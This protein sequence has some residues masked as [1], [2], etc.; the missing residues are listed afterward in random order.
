MAILKIVSQL[1]TIFFFP[2]IP[3]KRCCRL[4]FFSRLVPRKTR[5]DFLGFLL[6]LFSY[7]MNA[8][9]LDE[10]FKF[11]LFSKNVALLDMRWSYHTKR[12]TECGYP[13]PF[14]KIFDLFA[15]IQ[16]RR[17]NEILRCNNIS[18]SNG[19]VGVGIPI[20]FQNSRKSIRLLGKQTQ[21]ALIYPKFAK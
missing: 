4:W 1:G 7:T 9:H 16:R 20:M 3:E 18:F 5:Y 10:T 17:H 13:S 19:G 12:K 21:V 11:K 8:I 15:R 6:F 14:H 2:C